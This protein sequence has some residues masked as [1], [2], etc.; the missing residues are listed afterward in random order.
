MGPRELEREICH[1]IMASLRLA[2]RARSIG[3]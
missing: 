3:W 1:T 2:V